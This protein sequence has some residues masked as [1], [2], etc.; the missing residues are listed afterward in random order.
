MN[1]FTQESYLIRSVR[2]DTVPTEIYVPS[3]GWFKSRGDFRWN[4]FSSQ[5]AV[6]FIVAGSG[7][8]VCNGVEYSVSQGDWFVFWPDKHI[9]YYDFPE[10]PWEYYWFYFDG[11]NAVDTFSAIGLSPEYPHLKSSPDSRLFL[12]ALRHA[13]TRINH[14]RYSE[15]YPVSLAWQLLDL[16]SMEVNRSSSAIIPVPCLAED[17]QRIIENSLEQHLNVDELAKRL[18]VNRSTLFRVFKQRF[19]M[20]PKSYIDKLRFELACKLLKKSSNT[21]KEVS[22]AC[23]FEGQHYFSLAFRKRFGMSP[24]QYRGKDEV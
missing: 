22:Y 21:I 6:H 2:V 9:K 20:S 12:A 11:D 19:G 13:I 10:T 24:T 16:L 23:G 17:C 4:T 14:N 8:M 7:V 18:Q 15:F 1:N 5:I 3:I